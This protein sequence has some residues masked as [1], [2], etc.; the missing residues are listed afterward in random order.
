MTP[1]I[2]GYC[3]GKKIGGRSLQSAPFL[4]GGGNLP[5]KLAL[6][7]KNDGII[8]LLVRR[9]QDYVSFR[10]AHITLY[11]LFVCK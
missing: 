3:K 10:G 9:R 8:G 5:D 2:T 4:Q 11:L 1:V 7:C 6:R